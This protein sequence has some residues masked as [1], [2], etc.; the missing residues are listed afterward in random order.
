MPRAQYNTMM[1]NI[2]VATVQMEHV[3]GDKQANFAKIERI[4]CDAAQA[5]VEMLV[6]PECCI[7]GYWFLRNQTQEQLHRLAE[8]VPEGDST[9]KLLALAKHHNMTIG[10]G[11]VEIDQ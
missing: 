7:T 6:L 5:Q 2:R 4:A 3:A 10:A 1:R 9:Q 8:R 11:L